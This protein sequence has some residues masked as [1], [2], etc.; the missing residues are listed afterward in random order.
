MSGILTLARDLSFSD[1]LTSK[2]IPTLFPMSHHRRRSRRVNRRTTNAGFDAY[3]AASLHTKREKFIAA[4]DLQDTPVS[5]GRHTDIEHPCLEQVETMAELLG[6]ME[7]GDPKGA[8]A[9]IV[10]TRDSYPSPPGSNLSDSLGVVVLIDRKLNELVGQAAF[11]ERERIDIERLRQQLQQAIDSAETQLAMSPASRNDIGIE[12]IEQLYQ[13]LKLENARINSLLGHARAEYQAL[14]EFIENDHDD[15]LAFSIRN[16]TRDRERELCEEIDRLKAQVTQLESDLGSTLGTGSEN[17]LQKQIAD[18]RNQLLQSR[19]ETVD[20]RLQC[21]ELSA[22][23]AH[24]QAP[25]SLSTESYTWEERKRA[26][27]KQLEHETKQ[28]APIAP[29]KALEIERIIQQSGDEITR[30]DREIADLKSLLEQQAVATNGMAVGAAA[31][32]QIIEADDLIIEERQRLKQ[33]Q[34]EWEQKQRQAEIEMSLERAKL[35]RER[36]ELQEKMRNIELQITPR[37]SDELD[38]VRTAQ[39]KSR[40]NWLNRL[41]LHDT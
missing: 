24:Y 34:E 11:L 32:A 38:P 40:G 29:S 2:R 37:N 39:R 27:L 6:Q 16:E 13:S 5:S 30:R 17:E 14:L 36:L 8:I 4:R 10:P 12:E 33:I 19:H 22:R 41:G 15:D 31:I 23:L 9:C 7:T 3:A 21:N 1:D 35:A 20:L 28:D 18:L 26:W 25:T